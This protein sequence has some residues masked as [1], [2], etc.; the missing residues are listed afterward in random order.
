M[1]ESN[2]RIFVFEVAGL[3][4][5]ERTTLSQTPIRTSGNQF[6]QVPYS[7]MNQEMQR[8]LAL[9]GQIVSV[10]PLSTANATAAASKAASR[11]KVSEKKVVK[12]KASEEATSEKES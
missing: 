5:N 2:R 6:F 4:Q 8:I 11:K 10:Q 12:K 7:R 9:G 1:S 3:S